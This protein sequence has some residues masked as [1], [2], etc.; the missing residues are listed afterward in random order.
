MQAQVYWNFYNARNRLLGISI[1]L[2][3]GVIVNDLCHS[4][5]R[6]YGGDQP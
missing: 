4:V 3:C 5:K 2:T 6:A 1:L